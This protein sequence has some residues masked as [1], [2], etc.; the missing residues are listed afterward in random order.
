LGCGDLLIAFEIKRKKLFTSPGDINRA[1]RE[2]VLQ[3]IGTNADNHYSSPLV[4]VSALVGK[5][6][7]LLY[8]EIGEHPDRELRFHL[9]V[10]S[11]TS[12]GQLIHFALCLSE[13][14]CITSLFAS[15]PT[16][17][18]SPP[19]GSPEK[20]DE[21]DDDDENDFDLNADN[22]SISSA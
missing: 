16:P 2:G 6:H 21:K 5:K 18:C 10:R 7:F 14:T 1:L 20:G 11:S 22:V 15:P 19:Y 9:R 4:I 8:L 17:T 3:L 13:R 12:L